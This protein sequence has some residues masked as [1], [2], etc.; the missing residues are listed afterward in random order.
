MF[1]CLLPF[2]FRCVE[3]L[4]DIVNRTYHSG[5]SAGKPGLSGMGIFRFT[6][7]R[8]FH[9]AEK[10]HLSMILIVRNPKNVHE[11]AQKSSKIFKPDLHSVVS[12]GTKFAKAMPFYCLLVML[13]PSQCCW[14]RDEV[15]K[16]YAFLLPVGHVRFARYCGETFSRHVFSYGGFQLSGDPFHWR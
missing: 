11:K 6:R 13:G 9:L 4:Q 12:T 14:N 7:F 8:C 5:A 1:V 15:R 10:V 3:E 16:S 2:S